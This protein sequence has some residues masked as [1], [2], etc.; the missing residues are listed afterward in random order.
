[1][2][3]ILTR[4]PVLHTVDWSSRT[5]P[6]RPLGQARRRLASHA[7]SAQ[8]SNV[9]LWP[10]AH[11]AL[12]CCLP[13]RLRRR[14]QVPAPFCRS[15]RPAK[16]FAV[17]FTVPT[18]AGSSPVPS[19]GG[20]TPRP[21]ALRARPPVIRR[22]CC[23]GFCGRRRG[24]SALWAARPFLRSRRCRVSARAAPRRLFVPVGAPPPPDP[25]GALCAS[26]PPAAGPQPGAGGG[27]ARLLFRPGLLPCS[28]PAFRAPPAPVSRCVPCPVS[29]LRSP[30][31]M[32]LGIQGVA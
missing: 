25:R 15:C 16:R 12:F 11:G 2:Q 10:V 4:K 17:A 5:P 6:V 28:P 18:W 1:M 7:S 26:M 24:R 3:S 23:L 27:F 22:P 20:G 29:R 14:S 9:R 32:R 31:R 21:L 19:R 8:S 13:R 30:V